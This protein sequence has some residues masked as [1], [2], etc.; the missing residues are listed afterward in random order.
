MAICTRCKGHMS[1]TEAVCSHCGFDFPQDPATVKQK[2]CP[3]RKPRTR[4]RIALAFALLAIVSTGYI[5]NAFSKAAC[6]Q[7]MASHL[8]KY[9]GN[10]PFYLLL[11]GDEQRARNAFDSLHANYTVAPYN[12][13]EN[14]NWPYARLEA[15]GYLPFLIS[16]D[17]AW[18]REAE[19]G[20]GATR[21]YFN[22]FGSVVEI[23]DSFE[24]ST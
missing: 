21:W 1:Q 24:W 22:F 7:R 17:Y 6:E 3:A 18:E 8:M 5:S 13:R 14:I 23:G 15:T 9:V 20:G 2:T 11:E 10:R 19:L 12:P 16:V 4:L